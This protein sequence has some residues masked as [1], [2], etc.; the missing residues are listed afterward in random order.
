MGN[1]AYGAGFAD[2][3][4]IMARKWI[5]HIPGSLAQATVVAAVVARSA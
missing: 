5:G 3:L 1:L 4:Y 2:S